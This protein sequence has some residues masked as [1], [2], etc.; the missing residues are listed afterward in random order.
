MTSAANALTKVTAIN[1]PTVLVGGWAEKN[2][3]M[4]PANKIMEVSKIAFPVSVNV[5]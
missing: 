1:Q 5:I 4:N 2:K 3:I